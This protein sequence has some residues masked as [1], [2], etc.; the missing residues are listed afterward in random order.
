MTSGMTMMNKKGLSIGP[1]FFVTIYKSTVLL[2]SSRDDGKQPRTMSA[3]K[4]AKRVAIACLLCCAIMTNGCLAMIG[5]LLTMLGQALGDK[6]T[7]VSI[8]G[9][10]LT[11]ASQLFGGGGMNMGGSNFGGGNTFGSQNIGGVPTSNWNSPS[12]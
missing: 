11:G 1:P 12:G 10:A 5:Q 7:A 3:R 6:G 9:A 8:V 4:S 2:P